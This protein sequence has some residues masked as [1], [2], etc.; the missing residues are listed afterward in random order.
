[1][2]RIA[3]PESVLAISLTQ[4]PFFALLDLR[5]WMS[6]ALFPFWGGLDTQFGNIPNMLLV[7]VA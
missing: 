4:F 5:D 7:L 2:T 3:L 6:P 1:L